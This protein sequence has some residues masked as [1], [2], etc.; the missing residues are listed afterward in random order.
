MGFESTPL[1]LGNFIKKGLQGTFFGYP[2]I[3]L[4]HRTG[5]GVSRVGKELFAL[6]PP[7]FVQGSEGL[8]PM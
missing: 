1:A 4:T 3:E 5:G 6:L 7:A 8:N 2:R